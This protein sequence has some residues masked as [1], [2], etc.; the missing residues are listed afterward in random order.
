MFLLFITKFATFATISGCH[1]L[2]KRLFEVC[3]QK[4]SRGLRGRSTI[5]L[6]KNR[7][8]CYGAPPIYHIKFI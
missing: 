8:I 3:M 7:Q 2:R 5:C 1:G 6:E 4:D